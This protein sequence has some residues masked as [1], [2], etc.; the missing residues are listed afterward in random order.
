VADGVMIRSEFR[1][2][3]FLLDLRPPPD[4]AFHLETVEPG[5]NVWCSAK[6]RESDA[7]RPRPRARMKETPGYFERRHAIVGTD[8]PY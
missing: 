5:W 6:P 7:P 2:V 8:P 3:E 4:A 1:P